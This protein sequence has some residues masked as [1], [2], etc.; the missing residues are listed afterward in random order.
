MASKCLAELWTR[1]LNRLTITSSAHCLAERWTGFLSTVTKPLQ[2]L[3]LIG[4]PALSPFTLL[5]N[6]ADLVSH[7]ILAPGRCRGWAKLRTMP[8]MQRSPSVQRVNSTQDASQQRCWL[9]DRVCS[10]WYSHRRIRP[11]SRLRFQIG[12]SVHSFPLLICN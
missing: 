12:F 1:V 5:C 11:T 10:G 7:Y 8:C 6:G 3:T 9:I 2:S 4:F